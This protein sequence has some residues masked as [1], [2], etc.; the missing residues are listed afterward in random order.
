MLE[1]LGKSQAIELLSRAC[2][3]VLTCPD[4]KARSRGSFAGVDGN[5]LK[6]QTSRG[7]PPHPLPLEKP[8]PQKLPC[9]VP[10]DILR[11]LETS[12]GILRHLEASWGILNRISMDLIIT[13]APSHLGQWS[14]DVTAHVPGSI[15]LVESAYS[16]WLAG[17]ELWKSLD[18]SRWWRI[19][20]MHCDLDARDSC[21]LQVH[22]KVANLLQHRK[23]RWTNLL[24]RSPARGIACSS[25]GCPWFHVVSR[26]L[27]IWLDA[28]S[29]M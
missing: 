6:F 17:L 7:K 18:V 12:W 13:W 2:A 29:R 23:H 20:V 27:A 24:A 5:V 3:P 16:T 11:H 14:T 28:S 15:T 9:L 4:T 8:W 21:C 10:W 26:T 25:G 22:G 19:D 1:N